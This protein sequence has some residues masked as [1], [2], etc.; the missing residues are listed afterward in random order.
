VTLD[1]GRDARPLADGDP[2]RSPQP[3]DEMWRVG[4]WNESEDD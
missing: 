4:S 1:F 2:M 3:P